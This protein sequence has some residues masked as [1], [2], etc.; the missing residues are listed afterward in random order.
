MALTNAMAAR[1]E[2]AA[3][4]EATRKHLAR[5]EREFRGA[6]F[7][8]SWSRIPKIGAGL[9][10]LPEAVARNTAINLQTQAASMSKM[11]EAQLSTSFQGFT[12]ENMLRLVRLAMPNTCR[13]KVFTEFAMESAKDSIKYIKPV[14]SKTVHDGDLHDKH[15]S[16]E[17]GAYGDASQYVDKYNDINEDDFQRAL[18]E[19]TEDRFTQEL[20]NIP[21][22]GQGVFTIPAKAAE[23]GNPAV[24]A[25]KL[26]KGYM[27]I[28][29]GDETHPIA[30]E[31]KRTGNFFVNTA[32]YPNAEIKVEKQ[33]DG[34]IKITV[35]GVNSENVKVFARFDLEDDFLGDNLGE[36]ELVMSDYKFEPRPTTIGVTWSQLAE[37][38]LDASFGLSAQDMLVTYAGDAIRI[39]LD[40][41]SFKLAYGVARSNK[42]YVV[43]FD[44]AYGNGENIEG[45]FHT[46]QTF[47]SAVD[48]VTD[49]MVNDINRGGVSR[50]VA[51]F[52]AG[53]YLKLVKGTFSEKGRQSAKGIYQIGEF[54]GIPTFKA[55]SSIIPTNEI[56]CVW[57][58]DE[59]EGD[60]AIA[61]GTLVPFF[62]TGIIQRKNF[63]K[64]AGLATY[65]D[66]AVM[67]RR[68]LALI[69]I[70]GLKDTTAKVVGGMLKYSNKN[71]KATLEVSSPAADVKGNSGE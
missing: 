63:Y 36:I 31:N 44:A 58:D 47:P 26:I 62:N 42:D 5:T 14:Y 33:N 2:N 4:R 7:V 53:S 41:R 3:L 70:K 54:G 65:G 46:A 37:I 10:Q 19:N 39:N 34:S 21:G 11:T 27:K 18:Y 20:I 32:E 67:N 61:F 17:A 6:K 50:M 9:T 52:S 22:N 35:T 28:Y 49:I 38:T 13:N 15:T 68:Y 24:Y 8:E 43:E 66:W 23:G 48:T 40:L 16:N 71:A 51:G 69:R 59:N 64:E 56:M 57:K 45:Y 12:P 29:D 60:V 1:K 55:P 25:A 30:E